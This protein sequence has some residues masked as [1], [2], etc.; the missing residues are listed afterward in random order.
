MGLITAEIELANPKDR[1]I[2]PIKV[3]SFVDTGLLHL[4]IPWHEKGRF[5]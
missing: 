5:Q 1:K 2:R 3:E 4:C